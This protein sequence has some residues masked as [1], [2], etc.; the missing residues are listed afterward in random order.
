MDLT[1]LVHNLILCIDSSY[2]KYIPKKNTK[3]DT[4]LK[5]FFSFSEPNFG[6]CFV[7]SFMIY[8]GITT[9]TKMQK[10][11]KKI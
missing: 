4:K 1:K 10:I 8:E 6:H 7:E 3:L 9:I 11:I 5:N 2:D